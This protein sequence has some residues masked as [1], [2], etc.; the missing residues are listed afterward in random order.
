MREYWIYFQFFILNDWGKRSAEARS[1]H[2]SGVAIDKKL[3][4]RRKR[5]AF[6]DRKHYSKDNYFIKLLR[7]DVRMTNNPAS[8]MDVKR[9]NRENTLR[10]LLSCERISQPELSQKLNLSWPT[11]LQNVKELAA[12]GLVQEVGAYASTGGRKAKAYAPVVDAKLAVGLDI[13][14]NHVGLVLVDLS[15]KVVRYTRKKRVF[16]LNEEYF[17][18]LGQLLT[19]FLEAEETDKILGVGISLPGIV[20]ESGDRL[21]YSHALDIY[22]VDTAM[23]SRNIPFPCLFLNDAN[24]AGLAEVWGKLNVGNMVYLS[25]SNSVGGAI[26]PGGRLYTGTNLRAGEF[27]HNTL[28]PNG[29]K[30]YC[31]KEGCLDAYVS[32]KVL[33]GHTGGNLAQ[34]FD[35]LRD[36]EEEMRQAWKEYLEYLSVAINN[37]RMT[38]DC[39]VIAGGYVGAFLEEFGAPLRE[40]LAQRNTF[41][42]DGSYLKYCSFKL[43]ASAVGAALMQI[44]AFIHQI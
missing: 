25:L 13:T 27:G 44:E 16:A 39:D 17:Q 33:S 35:R 18:N 37:L 1:P 20:N 34:F 36:G 43:E 28:V 8:N 26:I 42:Q 11:V 21:L 6:F 19:E 9:L 4:Q 40:M 38:F 15:G 2:L 24:A 23:F 29:R 41:Q 5:L 10:C 3:P 22:D 31:G 14:Q 32:A 7:N 12:L 30:C